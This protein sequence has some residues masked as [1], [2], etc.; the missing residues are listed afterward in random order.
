MNKI[1]FV[2]GIPRSGTSFVAGLLHRCGVWTGDTI[3]GDK[4]NELGYYENK[5]LVDLTK[6]IM[7]Q[8]GLRARSDEKIPDCINIDCD[9]RIEVLNIVG[10]RECWL[11]KDSKLLFLSPL[12]VKAFPEATWI[13]PIRDTH[14][15]KE[16]LLRHVTWNRRFNSVMNKDKYIDS[17]ISRLTKR[18]NDLRFDQKINTILVNS[19][20][21]IQS[22]DA[23]RYFI[24]QKCGLQFDKEAYYDFVKPDIW[25]G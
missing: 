19:G 25:H 10:N 6:K 11:Y 22:E 24:E 1:F 18:M 15:I 4:Y 5:Q 16:S 8:N 21:L 20:S 14:K 13:L 23:A 7:R 3:Q 9:L 17:M 2:A 12:Y